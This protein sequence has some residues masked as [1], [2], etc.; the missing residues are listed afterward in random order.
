[1][2]RGLRHKSDTIYLLEC[3]FARLHQLQRRVAQRHRAGGDGSFL[4][5]ARRRARDDELAQLV[6]KHEQLADRLAALEARPPAVAATF[7]A[8]GGTKDSDKA[9]RKHAVQGRY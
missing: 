2:R 8:T 5:L 7:A 9:L 4:Q 1:M 3:G 6:V